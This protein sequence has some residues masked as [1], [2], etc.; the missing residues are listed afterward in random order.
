MKLHLGARVLLLCVVCL[1]PLQ[2]AYAGDGVTE[3]WA[4]LVGIS[5]YV[6]TSADLEYCDDDAYAIRDALLADPD[7]WTEDHITCV[8]NEDA[9]SANIEEALRRL[10]GE[11]DDDDLLLF[12]FSGH[13]TYGPDQW[14]IDEAD[15]FDEYLVLQNFDLLSD[16]AFAGYVAQIPCEQII[17]LFDCCFSGGMITSAEAGDPATRVRGF[18]PPRTVGTDGFTEDVV[19]RVGTQ[20]M[21]DWTPSVVVITAC[22]DDETCLEDARLGHGIFTWFLLQAMNGIADTRGDANGWISAQETYDYLY[23]PTVRRGG[24]HPQIFHGYGSPLQYLASGAPTTPPAAPSELTAVAVRNGNAVDLNWDDNA[25]NEDGFKVQRRKRN[26]DGSWPAAWGNMRRQPVNAEAWTDGNLAG[27]GWYQYRTRAFNG[28]GDS[29]WATSMPVQC[30]QPKPSRPTN[31]QATRQDEDPNLYLTW[32]DNADDETGQVLER[33]RRV[34][35]APDPV[36]WSDWTT[37]LQL[38]PNVEAYVDAV[39]PS[40]GMYQYRV[41][42]YNE[43]GPSNWSAR[44]ASWR[45]STKPSAPTDFTASA[46]LSNQVALAWNDTADN[47]V[48]FTLQRRIRWLGGSWPTDWE[49]VAWI[50]QPDAEKYTDSGLLSA[51]EYQYRLRAFNAIGPSNWAPYLRVITGEV[52]TTA[53]TALSVQQVSTQAVAITYSLSAEA[54]VTIEVR[55]IAGRMIRQMVAGPTGQGLQTATWNLRN[56]SGSPVPSGTYICTLIA[57]AQDGSQARAVNT[58]TVRR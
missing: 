25:G 1:V 38:A 45:Y 40:D 7:H 28:A 21:N 34:T 55:N 33:R 12:S 53:V 11:P 23:L 50:Y 52:S 26:T 5:D 27:S 41:R 46:V 35:C 9:T 13:G 24:H 47:N 17:L 51:R 43:A 31:L 15:G 6:G 8:I 56:A 30:L 19:K 4:V 18:G 3:Y 48:G 37:V 44:A 39:F 29:V 58:A 20:D 32:T 42:A 36:T 49:T 57:R 2:L 22:Q 14:P 10:Q 16:D 54:D